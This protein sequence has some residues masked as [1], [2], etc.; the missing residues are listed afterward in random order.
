MYSSASLREQIPELAMNLLR[1]TSP[2]FSFVAGCTGTCGCRLCVVLTLCWKSLTAGLVLPLAER[3]SVTAF[4]A[5]SGFL[6]RSGL[7]LLPEP[8]LRP[9]LFTPRSG[10]PA[11]AVLLSCPER[12]L[13]C[14]ALLS[15][16]NFLSGCRLPS[17]RGVLSVVLNSLNW[18]SCPSRVE[19]LL[20]RGL[21]CDYFLKFA[22]KGMS[23]GDK[24][25]FLRH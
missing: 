1:R 5:L 23:I 2:S 16:D 25:L 17:L 6:P 11:Y 8:L 19:G 14:P 18:P 13:C 10:L 9:A 21:I 15:A 20:M 3:L 4:L 24:F 7:P 22:R 12:L